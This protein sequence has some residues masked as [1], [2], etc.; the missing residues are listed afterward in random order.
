MPIK[1]ENR[2]RYPANWP[3]IVDQ[4]RER[5]GDRCEG[6][7]AFPDCRR[8]NGWLLNKTTGE[9]TDDGALAEAWEL[10]DGDKVVRIV[11]T[12]AHL[13]HV[14]EHCE[15]SNLRHWCQRCHLA[16]DQK[17]HLQTAYMARMARAQTLE[18]PL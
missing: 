13:D 4:V 11:L 9:L 18:L 7:P 1:P 10:A 6:S 14:P 15:L 12:T 3:E 17:H 5:S 16:Y 2:H 8:P